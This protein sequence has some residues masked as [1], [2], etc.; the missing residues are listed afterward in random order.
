MQFFFHEILKF[1]KEFPY[2]TVAS[3]ICI[4]TKSVGRVLFSLTLS[5]VYYLF[6]DRI[7]SHL[8][9]VRLRQNITQQSLADAAGVSLSS[10]KKIEKG[11]IGSFDSFL[12]VLRTL[13]KLDVLQPLVD[14]EQLSPSEYYNLVQSNTA[15]HQRQRAVGQFNKTTKEDSEW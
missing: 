3:S 14:E 4:S 8:K 10:L 11:E 9:A 2:C 12:R 7:G 6:L 1:S 15:K 13:G 5:S